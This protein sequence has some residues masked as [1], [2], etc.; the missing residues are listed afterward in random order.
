MTAT[1]SLRCFHHGE[2]V[3]DIPARLL[4]SDAPRY[5]PAAT[6][7]APAAPAAPP[8]AP[9]PAEAL[10]ALLRSPNVARK[11]WVYERY[12]HLVGSRTVR[13]PSLDAAVLR[14]RPSRRGLAVSL[15]GA[16]RMCALHPRAGGSLVVLEAARNVACA[17]GRPLAV[18]DC[19]NLGNPEKPEAA[20]ELLQVIE[21][22]AEACEA[23]R[24][25]VVSG[26]VSLYNETDG[27][28]IHPTPVVGC[29]G[30][31]DDVR[32]VPGSWR[33]GDAVLL[34]SASAV[35]LDGSEYQALFGALA[36]RPPR[37]DLAAEAA[38]VEFLWRSAP[39]LSLAHDV[40]LG[41][42]AACLAQA[43]IVSDAG[44]ELDL[45]DDALML[46][47]E[48]GGR[49]V[50]ACREELVDLVLARATTGVT[51]RRLGTVAGEHVLGTPLAELREAWGAHG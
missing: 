49:A 36:G 4:T 22:I 5:S 40:S 51:V 23:L 1:G 14:L 38:L 26:N 16:G 3:G 10:T 6:A 29:V 15:D 35:A 9:P 2:L 13:R 45:R 7:R 17:G 32:S 46:F 34:A 39:S 31:V 43:A 11:S 41:G 50:V 33:A 28:A 37:L 27:A 24:I 20:W 48:G 21:G 42:L 30:L 8:S 18:T 12:D 25:P 19:L 44:A 47:G